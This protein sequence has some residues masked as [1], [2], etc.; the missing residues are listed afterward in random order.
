MNAVAPKLQINNAML[1]VRNKVGTR[2]SRAMPIQNRL[3][4][5]KMVAKVKKVERVKVM[6]RMSGMAEKKTWAR[7][8]A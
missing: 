4:Q 2:T 7:R 8:K 6:K 1:P 3:A 5:R